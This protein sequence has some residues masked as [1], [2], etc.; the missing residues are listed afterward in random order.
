MENKNNIKSTYL[1]L[2]ILGIVEAVLTRFAGNLVAVAVFIT[3]MTIR[4]RLAKS[5]PPVPAPT[6]IKFMIA[7]SLV[8]F[9]TIIVTLIGI[10]LVFSSGAYHMMFS[11]QKFI[12]FLMTAAFIIIVIGCVIVYKE[13]KAIEEDKTI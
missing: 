2:F 1:L 5:D 11:I 7:G 4:S 13:Y 6:G 8:H 3:A 9:S 10:N 12:N